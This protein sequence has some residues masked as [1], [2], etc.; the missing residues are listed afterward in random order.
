MKQI[1]NTYNFYKYNFY[2]YSFFGVFLAFLMFIQMF[3]MC[4]SI[5]AQNISSLLTALNE[6]KTPQKRTDLCVEIGLLYQKDR[7]YQ[8]A[9]EYFTQAKTI[10]PISEKEKILNYLGQ[11]QSLKGD[12]ANAIITYKELFEMRKNNQTKARQTLGII[13][14][15]EKRNE[16]YKEALTYYEDIL[17][18]YPPQNQEQSAQ[19][20]NNIGF[21]YRKLENKEKSLETLQKALASAKESQKPE[22]IITTLLNTGVTHSTHKNYKFAQDFY[23]QALSIAK[24]NNLSIQTAETHNYISA[25]DWLQAKNETAL[26]NVQKAIKIAEPLQADQILLVSY[27]LLSD[28]HQQKGEFKEAQ[29]AYRLYEKVK[30]KRQDKIQT[31]QKNALETQVNIEKKES[32]IKSLLAEKEKQTSALRQ[33]ELEKQ[34]QEQQ[35]VLKQKELDLYKASQEQQKMRFANQILEQKRVEQMLE[36]TQ[37]KAQEDKQKSEIADLQNKQMLKDALLKEK[38][39]EQKEQQARN[40]LLEKDKALQEQ[41]LKDEKILRES[42]NWIISLGGICLLLVFMGLVHTFW[43]NAQLSKQ[44]KEIQNQN[45]ALGAKNNEITKQATELEQK[46]QEI[47]AINEELHQNQEE[48]ETQ[49]EYIENTNKDL[50]KKNQKLI[51]NEEILKKAMEK[52]KANE[53]A[54][55]QTNAELSEKDKQITNSIKAALAIQEAILPYKQKLDS[56]L[57]DFFVIYRPKDV[58]SG[59]FYWLNEVEDRTFLIAVDCTGHGVPGAFM[60]LIANTLLDKIIRVWHIYSPKDILNQMQHEVSTVLRQD[61]TGNNNGMDMAV[62]CMEKNDNGSRHITFA[63]AKR[64]FY[65]LLPDADMISELEGDRKSIGGFQNPDIQFSNKSIILPQNSLLYVG[66]DGIA[67][68]NNL[69]RKRLTESKLKSALIE[70]AKFDMPTQKEKLENLIIEH[71]KDTTQRDDMLWIGV[72]I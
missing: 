12:Y 20:Y 31:E 2:K 30:T 71:M 63:G 69:K 41:Q 42:S 39:L 59:D 54:L 21:L 68:Q 1:Y 28:I 14:D 27:K 5:K 43:T 66:S 34:Q 8:K 58:V 52:L 70:N 23:T 56:L 53:I 18:N 47:L 55:I 32:E 11:A 44:K 7:A 26:D 72:K 25:N 10:S 36:I 9:V 3:L 50:Q 46:N 13:A 37:R 38:E 15:L 22:A 61:D 60:S 16:N 19:I 29:E 4:K 17:K 40:Q 6:E 35:L 24:K 33:S 51:A 65:F 45:M 67:D 57:K 49:R 62:V 64:P 48:L